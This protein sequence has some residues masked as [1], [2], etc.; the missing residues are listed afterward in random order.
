MS[1]YKV[2]KVSK[3]R[4]PGRSADR[5]LFTPPVSDSDEPNS[6]DEH[7]QRDKSALQSQ[8]GGGDAFN[9]ELEIPSQDLLVELD[10]LP[11]DVAVP[12]TSGTN[13]TNHVSNDGD[14]SPNLE[15]SSLSDNLNN[16]ADLSD[17]DYD[18]QNVNEDT[19]FLAYAI[20]TQGDKPNPVKK[21][22]NL[23]RL[24]VYSGVYRRIFPTQEHQLFTLIWQMTKNQLTITTSL[25]P[26]M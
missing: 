10:N 2:E 17:P 20:A 11:F 23:I 1:F 5:F 3:I 9:M 7:E 12:S 15:F 22:T 6:E 24:G 21:E 16:P 13:V 18:V 19:S 8:Y 14:S 4:V 26:R 25:Y